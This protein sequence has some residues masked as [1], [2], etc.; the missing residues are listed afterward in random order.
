MEW[1]VVICWLTVEFSW[2]LVKQQVSETAWWWLLLS[3]IRVLLFWWLWLYFKVTAMSQ[4]AN[5]NLFSCSGLVE[6]QLLMI[7][8]VDRLKSPL[9]NYQTVYGCYIFGQEHTQHSFHESLFK[10]DKWFVLDVPWTVVNP[11]TLMFYFSRKLSKRDLLNFAGIINFFR[12]ELYTFIYHFSWSWCTFK[13]S[14]M[15]KKVKKKCC[16]IWSF[17]LI[18][19]RLCMV[20][21]DLMTSEYI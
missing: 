8:A 6:T 19:C 15:P 3:F 13:V 11:L 2:L 1:S 10:G 14:V 16:D 7:C 5:W 21:M 4:M 20:F 9:C 17:Y 18:E 12:L